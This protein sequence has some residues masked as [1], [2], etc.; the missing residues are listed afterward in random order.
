MAAWLSL[1][2]SDLLWASLEQR[3]GQ[4]LER[5]HMPLA[6]LLHVRNTG[7]QLELALKAD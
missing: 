2:G 4:P 5:G 6:E 3:G 7:S 1:E